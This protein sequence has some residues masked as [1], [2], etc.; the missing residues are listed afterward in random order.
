[1]PNLTKVDS[2][3]AN[4]HAENTALDAAAADEAARQADV[5]TLQA[6]L[7]AAE[8]ALAA[9]TAARDAAE[10]AYNLACDDLSEESIAA[11]VTAPAARRY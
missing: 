7:A 2:A 3:H 4:L 11:K 9:A 6:Q 8:T 1:M 10:A 5:A